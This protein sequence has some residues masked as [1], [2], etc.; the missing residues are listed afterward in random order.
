M[1]IMDSILK[2]V[3]GNYIGLYEERITQIFMD[4]FPKAELAEKKSL[5]KM[6]KTWD[7]FFRSEILE[8]IATKLDIH[9]LVSTTKYLKPLN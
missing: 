2:N 7:L 9:E 6:F 5:I 4:S 8:V 1:Y 3:Q